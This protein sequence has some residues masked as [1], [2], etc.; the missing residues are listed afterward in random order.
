MYPLVLRKASLSLQYWYSVIIYT[1]NSY[2]HSILQVNNLY[3]IKDSLCKKWVPPLSSRNQFAYQKY[4]FL[5]NMPHELKMTP[6]NRSKLSLKTHTCTRTQFLVTFTDLILIFT[7]IFV[8]TMGG[9]HFS[10]LTY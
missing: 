8:P 3:L 2:G 10:N 5:C 4:L 1:V 9:F 7:S 6:L